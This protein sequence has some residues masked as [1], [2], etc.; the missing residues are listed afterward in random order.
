MPAAH[1]MIELWRGPLCESTH[2]GHAVV[3]DAS[4][5]VR[6]AWGDPRAVIYPRSSVK[7][8]QA[9]PM[10]ESGVSLP[11]ERLALACASHQGAAVHTAAVRAWL[12][13]AGFGDDDLLCGREAPRDRDLRHAL[14]REGEPPCQAH[15]QCSGKHAGF[16]QFQKHLRAEGPYVDPEGP[17]QRVVRGTFEE[18]TG[19]DSPGYGIDGCAAP[20][21]ATTVAGLARA[22]AAVAAAV[23]GADARQSAMVTLREAMMAHPVLVA[24]TGR[25]TTRLMAA[26]KGRAAVKSGAEGVFVAIL[27]ELGLGVALK[28]ADGAARAA[29]AAMAAL[30]VRLGVLEAGEDAVRRTLHAPVLNRAGAKVGEIRP[31]R[32]F[33]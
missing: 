1:P 16:L 23:P 2:A 10:V 25:P 13:D 15:N 29:D 3:C 4:G 5:A 30:L 19:E 9:L 8:I 27:P 21:F 32:G 18:V 12:A 11:A 6:D 17:V 31:A 26:A 14:I 33:P 20:N 24:G 22:M 28:I 7:M